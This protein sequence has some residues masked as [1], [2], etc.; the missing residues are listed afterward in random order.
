MPLYNITLASDQKIPE[1]I[2]QFFNQFWW[3][4]EIGARNEAESR[5]SALG[6][7]AKIIGIEKIKVEP[8]L[9][10]IPLPLVTD[11]A[12]AHW[13]IREVLQ[14][15]L[16]GNGSRLPQETSRVIEDLIERQTTFAA[17]YRRHYGPNAIN[18]RALKDELS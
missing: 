17:Q 15:W 18:L 10:D 12:L 8:G 6:I 9:F 16:V 5:L 7:N 4:N 14:N 1:V 11:K 2:L 13:A 3:V